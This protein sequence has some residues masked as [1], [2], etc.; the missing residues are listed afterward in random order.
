MTGRGPRAVPQRLGRDAE[1]PRQ[2]VGLGLRIE[3]DSVELLNDFKTSTRLC[4]AKRTVEE[5]KGLVE[6]H[7]RL[8]SRVAVTVTEVRT[9]RSSVT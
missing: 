2:S 8:Y 7:C 1:N 5:T 4:H 6:R 9:I 3:Q